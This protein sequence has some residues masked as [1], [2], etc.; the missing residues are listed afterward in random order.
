MSRIPYPDVA[1]ASPEVQEMFG[2]LQSLNIY[3]M[4]VHA[5]SQM[6]R[7]V[8]FGNGLLFKTAIDPILRE[9]AILR[10]GYLSKASYEVHQHER[11]SRDLGMPDAKMQALKVGPEAPAFNEL[12][13]LVVRITDEVVHNVKASDATFKVLAEK[14]GH[15]QLSEL[16]LVIGFY[17]MVCRFLENFEV[18]IEPRGA[19]KEPL[20]KKAK[21]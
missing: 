4:M 13:R 8:R 5:D 11:I 6:P 7:F 21:G 15:R 16:I 1:K 9:M 14:L 18:D 2:K 12:E 17:M 10:V 19:V 20:A 3:R